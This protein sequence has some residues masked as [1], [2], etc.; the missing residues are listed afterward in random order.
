MA[1]VETDL[2][3]T[4]DWVAVDHFDT[5]HSHVHVVVRGVIEDGRILNIA[6]DYLSYGI[7]HRAGE[8]LTRDQ[9]RVDIMNLQRV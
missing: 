7:P 8:V 5:G 4:L 9:V 1:K 3:T 6:G 2:G